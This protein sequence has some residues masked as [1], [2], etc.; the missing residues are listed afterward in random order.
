MLCEYRNYACECT[1]TP[2]VYKVA[3]YTVFI[4][5][6]L[7][8]R[9]TCYP[10]SKARNIHNRP[11]VNRDDQTNQLQAMQAEIQSLR[12]ELIRAQSSGAAVTVD[13]SLNTEVCGWPR[14]GRAGSTIVT[15]HF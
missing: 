1:V 11:V 12:D 4:A 7:V 2:C 9:V 3:M 5:C 13:S 8:L 10:P 15:E 14:T 6:L